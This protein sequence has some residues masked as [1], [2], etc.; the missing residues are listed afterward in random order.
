ML[1]KHDPPVLWFY[2]IED[3]FNL[4]TAIAEPILH[5]LSGNMSLLVREQNNT[6]ALN[7][8]TL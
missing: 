2:E 1:D 8:G 4:L 5:Y 6:G 3:L 7:V